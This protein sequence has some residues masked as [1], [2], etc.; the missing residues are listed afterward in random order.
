MLASDMSRLQYLSL[1]WQTCRR[2]RCRSAGAPLARAPAGTRYPTI[3]T[4]IH[5]DI[6]ES[7]DSRISTTDNPQI[8]SDVIGLVTD[9]LTDMISKKTWTM[10]ICKIRVDNG[11]ISS[12]F[13]W[14]KKPEKLG[15]SSID[16]RCNTDNLGYHSDKLG[17]R[18][19]NSDI[20]RMTRSP[21]SH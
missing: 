3:S 2:W 19:D 1:H 21:P 14:I 20:P 15:P 8:S 9:L 5:T 16:I 6:L 17:Y 4:L 7:R 18:T 10:Q 11:R 12:R 13:D